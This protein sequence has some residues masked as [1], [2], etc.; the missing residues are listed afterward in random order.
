MTGTR[1]EAAAAMRARLVDAAIAQLAD[2]GMRGLTHRKVGDR[3]G[4]TLGLVRYHFGSL[5]GLIEAA[6]ERMMELQLDTVIELG[7][8]GRRDVE[9]HGIASPVFQAEARRVIERMAAQSEL[10]RARFELLLHASRHPE[11]QETIRRSRDE[12]VSRIIAQLPVPDP[13]AAARMLI[14]LLDGVSL[15]QLSGFEPHLQETAPSMLIAV[16]AA[17]TMLPPAQNQQFLRS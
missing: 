9:A 4:T 6:L 3:A 1:R 8:E 14:A 17:A 13:D 11:L 10:Q 12:F 2:E 5:D 7:E 15:H 16:T